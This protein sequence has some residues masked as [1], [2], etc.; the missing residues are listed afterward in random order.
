MRAHG[1]FAQARIDFVLILDDLN[2]SK[3]RAEFDGKSRR[4]Q[5]TSL[6]RRFAHEAVAPAERCERSRLTTRERRKMNNLQDGEHDREIASK[7]RVVAR[8]CNFP[9]VRKDLIDLAARYDRRA[10][11]FDR[12]VGCRAGVGSDERR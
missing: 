3:K 10:D 1:S 7:L 12:P 8:R 2:L 5:I 6:N 11:H 9:N 4:S